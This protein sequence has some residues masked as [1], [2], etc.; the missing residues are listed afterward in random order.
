MQN[1]SNIL[2]IGT[3]NKMIRDGKYDETHFGFNLD[4]LFLNTDEASQA[5]QG[6]TTKVG[7]GQCLTSLI[8]DYF[9]TWCYEIGNDSKDLAER[10]ATA[11]INICNVNY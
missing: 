8:Y 4:Y 6:I 7:E 9:K 5:I 11:Y 1:T 2:S 10:R 3:I